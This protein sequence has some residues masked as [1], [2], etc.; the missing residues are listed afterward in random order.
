MDPDARHAQRGRQLDQRDE[1]AIVGMDAARTD[2]AD[3][4]QPAVRSARRARTPRRAR[5]GS[6]TCRRRSP[7]RSAAGP[8]APGRPAPRFRWPTSE[9][10]IWPGGRP[11]ASSEAPQDRVRPVAQQPAPDRHPGR[12]DRIG[13]R[14]AADPEAVEHD[15]DDRARPGGRRD[16]SGHPAIPRA[17][18][19]TPARATIPAISSGLS[20]A[21]PTSAPS[22]DG[23]AMNS[24]IADDVTLPP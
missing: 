15:Q 7:R 23:S 22:I 14:V 18:A 2:Q 6:R 20:D 19:V 1:M 5:V 16:A 10:P 24:S 8:G 3:Q 21:P 13:G 12:G 17:A 11:T 9:L 4:V